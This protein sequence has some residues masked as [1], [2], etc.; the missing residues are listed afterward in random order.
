MRTTD[1]NKQL[2]VLGVSF[3]DA[4]VNVRECL[5]FKQEATTSLLHEASIE[6]PSL[7][8]LVISTCNRTEFYL[9]ALP[10]SGAEET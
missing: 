10:G 6:S 8:A 3:H 4:P 7:E 5:C 9:A 2:S 1:E